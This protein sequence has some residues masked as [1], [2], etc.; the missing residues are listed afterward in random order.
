MAG[1][2]QAG[3]MTQRFTRNELV[4]RLVR[5][6]ELEVSGEDQAEAATYFDT[7]KFRFHGPDGFE[8]DFAGLTAYFASVREAFDDRAIRRGIVVAEDDHLACQT[9]IE[10]TFAREFTQSPVGPLPPNGKRVVFDLINIFRF[11]DRGRLV[12][13]WVRNDSRSLLRQLGAE[14]S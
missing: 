1:G 2:R 5:A 13:E 4:A 7:E 14:G 8:S 3:D 10:G 6:G 12:E 11:D 9:W